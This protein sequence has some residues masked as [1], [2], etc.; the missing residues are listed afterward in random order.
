MQAKSVQDRA[1]SRSSARF[2]IL[3]RTASKLF[4]LFVVLA[5]AALIGSIFYIPYLSE[6]VFTAR[7]ILGI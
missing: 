7:E 5:V 3:R 2:S 1:L 4:L 6:I